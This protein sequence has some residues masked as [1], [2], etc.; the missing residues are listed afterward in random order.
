M[1]NYGVVHFRKL[2]ASYFQV[3]RLCFELAY[4]PIE[5][6]RHLHH[7]VESGCIGRP[8]G[9]PEHTQ[10]VTSR[11][12]R[13]IHGALIECCVNGHAYTPKNTAITL[14]GWRRCREC[15]RIRAFLI[16]EEER[17]A[18]HGGR[19]KYKWHQDKL[20]THCKYGHPLS[21]ENAY[22]QKTKWGVYPQCR[23]CKARA[24]KEFRDRQKL[25]SQ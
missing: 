25:I 23:Q 24:L 10:T 5:S 14:E 11:E 2:R 3:H 17:K 9:N 21:G 18:E 16:R 19:P 8:C 20:K 15:D 7:K 6:G 4:G 12:H 1:A 22:W 13:R